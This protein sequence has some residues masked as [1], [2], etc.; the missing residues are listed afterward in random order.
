MLPVSDLV[1]LAIKASPNGLRA[2][3]ALLSD[4]TE[5]G[6]LSVTVLPKPWAATG[7]S[8]VVR[9][10]KHQAG[11]TTHVVVHELDVLEVTTGRGAAQALALAVAELDDEIE[12]EGP[13]QRR[14]LEVGARSVRESTV[15]ASLDPSYT[16]LLD[17]LALTEHASASRAD[18]TIVGRH[19]SSILRV[20]E[21]L[22][23]VIAVEQVIVTA[24]PR[25]EE[26]TDDL[27][28]PRGRIHERTLLL[29]Q[30]SKFP[31]VTS[32]FD[33]LTL[34]TPILRVAAAALRAVASDRHEAEV[35]ALVGDLRHRAVR[36]LRVLQGTSVL[37]PAAA[38]RVAEH[39]AV[40]SLDRPWAP[41]VRLALP[42]LRRLG[43]APEPGVEGARGVLALTLRMEKVWEEWLEL[44]FPVTW[45]VVPQ[46]PT[47]APWA[48]DPTI[49]PRSS[50]VDFLL[51]LEDGMVAVVDAKYKLDKGYVSSSDGYQ[52]FAYS[53]LAKLDGVSPHAA[54]ILY[55]L[56]SDDPGSG[57]GTLWRVSDLNFPLW[58]IGLPFANRNDIH[59]QLA[60]SDYLVRLRAEVEKLVQVSRTRR[61]MSPLAGRLG[62]GVLDSGEP[63]VSTPAPGN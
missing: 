12:E 63:L 59:S 48:K 11:T 52:L 51:R 15:R 54:A 39:V 5:S 6:F 26:R 42:V 17:I 3:F 45:R 44:A 56:L 4:G 10:T 28:V 8:G 9:A 20:L 46:A 19:S 40:G 36:L 50:N 37:D 2:G 57:G 55:P 31:S 38:L 25:Y 16:S 60:F 27:T 34:N 23:F 24:R 47:S 14:L 41:V 29:S 21:Q 18:K 33:E 13:S 61:V 7:E 53:S 1:T 43:V 49:P 30:W 58:R 35:V 32:T 22:R 62:L